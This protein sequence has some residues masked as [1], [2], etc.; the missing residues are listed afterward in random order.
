MVRVVCTV[1]HHLS[2][3]LRVSP[4]RTL[5]SGL[6][7]PPV[8]CVSSCLPLSPCVSLC[9]RPS[10][11]P[12]RL[13]GP[14]QAGPEAPLPPFHYVPLVHHLSTLHRSV[15][16]VI[17]SCFLSICLFPAPLF[18]RFPSEEVGLRGHRM[19]GIP[20]SAILLPSNIVVSLFLIF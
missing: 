19:V 18:L 15:C 4:P 8:S 9:S 2:F 3:F 7:S 6:L 13:A 12:R 17:T 10:A 11:R 5:V 20:L 14:V 16:Y 1:R